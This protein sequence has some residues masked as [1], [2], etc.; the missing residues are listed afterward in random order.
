MD[1]FVG[2][3]RLECHI[4]GMYQGRWELIWLIKAGFEEKKNYG[5]SVSMKHNICVMI[6]QTQKKRRQK[7]TEDW[8]RKIVTDRTA[9]GPYET[10]WSTNEK[11]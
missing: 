11:K 8:R 5:M 3:K 2:G 10:K 1:I 6:D 4:D 9:A 7:K